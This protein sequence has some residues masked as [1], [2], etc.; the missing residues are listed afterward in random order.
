MTE[1]GDAMLQAWDDWEAARPLEQRI[2]TRVAFDALTAGWTPTVAEL[3]PVSGL[4][5]DTLTRT[6]EPMVTQGLATVTGERIT[7]IGG[8]SLVPAPHALRW[9]GRPYWTWCALDAIGI[10]AVLGGS[11]TVSSRVVPDDEAITLTFEGGAW[12]NPDPTLGIRLAD[13][14]AA[15]PLCTGT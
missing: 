14:E 11:A 7:G 13:P 3:A 9:Q 12:H 10:P 8:L 2:L 6:L 4:S 1:H 5:I 15:R